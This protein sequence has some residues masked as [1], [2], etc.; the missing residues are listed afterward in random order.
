MSDFK[1]GLE[2]V[3]AFETEIAEPDREGGA[4]RYRGVDIEELVGNYRFEQVWG[5]LVDESFSP[6]LPAA[7]PYEGGGLTG[8]TPADLQAVTARLGGEWDV[9]K[10][11]DISDDEAREDL[12]RLS[13]QFISIAAQSARIADGND[14]RIAP[15]TVAQ[16]QTTAERFFLEWRGEADPKHVQALDTYWICTCEH[17]L[18]ASTF[19]ARITAS[20]GSDCAAALSSAV[21][22]LSGPLHGGA[23]ARVLPML[24]AAAESGDPEGY[25]QGLIERGE[26]LMGF[27]HRVYRA[28]DPRARLLKKTA[29]ELGR[30]ALRG[31]RQARGGGTR[32]AAEEV[33]RPPARDERRVLV[34][35]RARRRRDPAGARACD[36]RVLADSRL[37]GAHP[38]A[39]EAEPARAAVGP[40]RRPRPPSGLLDLVNLAEAAAR[41]DELAAAGDQ[42]ELATLRQQWDEELEHAAR[43]PD[44]RIRAQAYR[45]IAQFRFR[46]KLELVRRGLQDESPAA[47]GSALIALE[48]L[49]RDHPGDVN[50]MRAILHEI[51]TNDPNLAVRR[52]GIVVLKNGSPQRE[53]ILVLNGLADDDEQDAELRKTAKAVA[54][55][56]QKRAN[57][58]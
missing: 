17:G 16:G 23:P 12:R 57:T 13:A 7:E 44:Y 22:A 55:A 34:G 48:G 27:G 28:E 36:V 19:V 10:L 53:T 18:N 38:R 54:T 24:D 50:W 43:S 9:K 52:L 56:L 6:G 14:D 21:G 40:L 39:E 32:S 1:P 15:Q 58:K 47:R 29:K 42:K 2:G 5:L 51:A 8:N 20:T 25:V 31:R 35:G 45:A 33:A 37:V 41:A 30:A 46:Q 26:R 4:L 11:I 3:V 49:S